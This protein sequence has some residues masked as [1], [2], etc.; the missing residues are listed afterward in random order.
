LQHI[1]NCDIEREAL[2][3]EMNYITSASEEGMDKEEIV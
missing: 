3:A 1:L 2:L